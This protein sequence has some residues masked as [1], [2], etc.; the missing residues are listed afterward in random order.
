MK[1]IWS[2]LAL[3]LAALIW[4]S[5]FVI[6]KNSTEVFPTFIL[7]G[8]RFTIGCGALA[9]IFL[10][11]LRGLTRKTL[12]HGGLIGLFLFLAYSVQTIGLV[13]TTPGKNAFLTAVYCVLTPFVYWL[14]SRR[15]PDK[16]N[17]LAAVL[18]LAG[19]GFVSLDEALTMG[20]GDALTLLGGLF[21]A[22]H[23]VAVSRFSQG[24]DPVVLTI[25]QFATAALCAWV[26][27]LFTESFPT[28]AGLSNWAGLLYLGLFATG[29]A[30]L[31]QNIGQKYTPA[32]PAAILLS[33]EGV[34]GVLFSI[35]FY[36]EQV[37]LQLGIGFALI[38]LAVIISETKLQ[39]LRR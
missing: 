2:R 29:G 15:M 11:K 33:L 13:Y 16:Y 23:L 12:L 10:K 37:T 39:F 8:L 20:L 17:W 1:P 22:L 6:M 25:L 18:C 21:Y 35:I 24:D 14:V 38:F 27:A 5:S 26:F 31:L 30:L 36:H 32:A 19:I 34:F 3:L 9:L 28:Q 7:L 4:G